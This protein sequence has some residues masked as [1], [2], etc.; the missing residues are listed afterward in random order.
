[1]KTKMTLPVNHPLRVDTTETRV[2][3]SWRRG[4]RIYDIM[5]DHGVSFGRFQRIIAR[6]R[7]YGAWI[8]AN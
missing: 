5:R 1:M 2:I 3:K 8:E 7:E 4:S 6:D